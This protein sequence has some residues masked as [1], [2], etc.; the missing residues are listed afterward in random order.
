MQYFVWQWWLLVSRCF[1]CGAWLFS[2]F[3]S[4]PEYPSVYLLIELYPRVPENMG[5]Q[6][7][8]FWGPGVCEFLSKNLD[9]Q[10]WLWNCVNIESKTPLNSQCRALVKLSLAC[11]AH[12]GRVTYICVGKLTIIGSDS[13]LSP[14]LRQAIIWTNAGILKIRPL[15]TNFSEIL[16]RIQAFSFQKIHLKMLSAKWRTSCLSLNG[17]IRRCCSL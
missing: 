5:V 6:W 1:V 14:G 4:L 9:I 13:G 11:L 10:Y 2:C 3:L 15:W 7:C 8:F 16:I 17:L 12:W